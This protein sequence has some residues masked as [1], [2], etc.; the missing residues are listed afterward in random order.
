MPDGSKAADDAGKKSLQ[1][2]AL[3][4]LK[5]FVVVAVYLWVLFVVFAAYKRVLLQENGVNLWSQSFAI[6]NALVFGKVILIAQALKLGGGLKKQ[7]LIWTVLGRALLFS[8]VLVLFHIAEE[9]IR[10]WIKDLPLS[11]AV[12]DFGEATWFGLLTY[13]ALFF[14]ALIP[15]F[16]VQELGDVIGRDALW[17]LFFSRDKEE[18]KLARE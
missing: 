4:E 1:Q 3:D 11:T 5:E 7:A 8:V 6:V 12:Q 14:V 18:L 13:A 17:D 16:A 9:A 15:F 2:R 10:A